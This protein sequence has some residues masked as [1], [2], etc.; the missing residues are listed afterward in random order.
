M[1]KP[2]DEAADDF[3]VALPPRASA[4]PAPVASPATPQGETTV[5]AP[6]AAPAPVAA[7][8]K[9]QAEQPPGPPEDDEQAPAPPAAKKPR[10]DVDAPVLTSANMMETFKAQKAHARTV[11]LEMLAKS[12]PEVAE[13]IERNRELE[14]EVAKLTKGK[15]KGR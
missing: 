3:E 15:T 2:S 7:A 9:P 11:R 10:Q 12:N 13:L 8:E 6:A 14:A 1:P 5:S 4:A